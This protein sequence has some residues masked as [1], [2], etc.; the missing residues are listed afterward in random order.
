MKKINQLLR[1]ALRTIVERRPALAAAYR[2]FRDE[3]HLQKQMALTTPLGFRLIGDKS[4]QKGDF[5]TEETE[6]LKGYMQDSDVLVDIGAYVGYY[7]CLAK[8][9]GKTV[10]AIEPLNQNQKVL[11]RNLQENGWSDVEVWPVGLASCTGIATVYG[12]KTGASMIKGWAGCSAVQNQMVSVSTL[13]TII[14]ARF[15]G[16]QLVIKVDVEGTEFEVL[17]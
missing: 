16:Q 9:M 11:Y 4:M 12:A 14:G 6:L 10:V 15:L 13:D 5:E 2:F 3:Q 17:K 7:S 8:S 1:S